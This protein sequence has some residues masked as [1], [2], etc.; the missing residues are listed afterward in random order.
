V[1]SA[2]EWR[3]SELL[4]RFLTLTGW[5]VDVRRAPVGLSALAVR[6][7]G[8]PRVAAW[9]VNRTAIAVLLFHATCVKPPL[10]SAFS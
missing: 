3:S 5:T 2:A 6:D 7:D 8:S 9:G 4:L 10:E 1:A